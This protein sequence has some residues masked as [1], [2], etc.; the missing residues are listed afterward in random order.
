MS[1][2]PVPI[3]ELPAY[4][5]LGTSAKRT[6]GEPIAPLSGPP[7]DLARLLAGVEEGYRDDATA[8]LS[9]WAITQMD[10][11]AAWRFIVAW[12]ENNQPPQ[13]E[14]E[15]RKTFK[16]ILKAEEKKRPTTDTTGELVH[17]AEVAP[18]RV[19]WL[20]PGYLPLGKLVVLDGDP[21]LGKSTLSLLIAAYVSKGMF[22]PDGSRCPVGG[23]VL[24]G[25]EDDPG[26]TIRPRLDAASADVSRIVALV[27]VIDRDGQR[28]PQ[29]PDDLD[30]IEEAIR[31]V[32]ARLVIV[33]PLMA[34]LGHETNAHRDQHVRRA[35]AP[36][37]RLAERYGVTVLVVRHLNKASEGANPL[38]RGGGSIGII[39]A[40][41]AG[42]LVAP[43]PDDESGQRRVLAVTKS[44]LGAKPPSLGFYVSEASNGA[45][46]IGWAG[47][48][49]QTAAHLL[50]SK[51]GGS[52]SA[53]SE[54]EE[55]LRE[56]LA[57]GPK[58]AKQLTKEATEAG[59]SVR[60]LKRAKAALGVRS[61][62][63]SL[64]DGWSWVTPGQLGTLGT[65]G[66]L[67]AAGAEKPTD[68][69]DFERGKGGGQ[70]GQ[71]GQGRTVAPWLASVSQP[72]RLRWDS[73]ASRFEQAAADLA[74]E[75][76]R[77]RRRLRGEPDPMPV[78]GVVGPPDPEATDARW[79]A[80]QRVRET[81]ADWAKRVGG[82][83]RTV[84]RLE[85]LAERATQAASGLREAES[86]ARR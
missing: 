19:Q 67:A 68:A 49:E 61:K 81:L 78:P 9:G 21:G 63:I 52:D 6:N 51:A 85:Q 16:S 24:L 69:S 41:R 44:N 76:V 79:P 29:L 31:A 33:D 47:E 37:A 46:V 7:F 77:R 2:L 39:G 80:T 38:Y 75:R 18:R 34:F 50:A 55:F 42:L 43:D 64:F 35:L 60:T 15:L 71:G 8:S 53:L 23:V 10:P 27:S 62:K 14:G 45:A 74:Y 12:N 17:L 5:E 25:A 73:A 13:S 26:D 56:Q 72:P 58:P 70:E 4:R 20:W 40:V 82:S 84:E 1:G 3:G 57:A 11:A 48:V 66:T 83:E 36:L 65:L 54:A 30:R 22:W 28:L 86:E 32:G 59:I